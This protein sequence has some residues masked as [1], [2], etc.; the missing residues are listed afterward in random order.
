MFNM[1]QYL[2]ERFLNDESMASIL[3]E[4]G[5][6]LRKEKPGIKITGRWLAIQKQLDKNGKFFIRSLADIDREFS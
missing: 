6:Q 2:V 4:A 3:N 1:T 5:R